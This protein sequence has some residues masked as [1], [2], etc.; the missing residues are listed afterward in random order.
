MGQAYG[1]HSFA[2]RLRRSDPNGPGWTRR[3]AGRGFA[4][5]DT[6]GVLIRDDRLDRLR[7][8][9]IP[10]AWKDVWICPWPNGHIQATGVD[11][12]GRRQYR[13]HEEWRA[14]RDAE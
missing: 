2:V 9:A 6:D 13:Y 3:R 5:Y 1:A 12:A 4:Y 11:A 14:R 8:L 7:G 10:P